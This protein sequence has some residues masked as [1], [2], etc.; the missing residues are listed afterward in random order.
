MLLGGL[1]ML[2]KGSDW[3]VVG[4]SDIAKA[5]KIPSLVIGLTIVAFGTSAPE[6][7]VS[8]SASLTG[9][10][11]VALGNVIG[12]NIFN[13]LMVVG[14]SSCIR[15][16]Y[17]EKEV[18]VRDYPFNIL[19]TLVLVFLGLDVFLGSGSFNEIS[20]V[21]GLVLLSFF[22]VFMY[23]TVV[24]AL[25]DREN[26]V[27]EIPERKMLMSI[28]LLVV[29]IVCVVAGGKF[30]VD[31]ACGIAR[32]FSVSENMIALT[33]IAIGTSLPELVT[34]VT[35]LKKGESD[36]AIGNVIGSNLFNIL[37]IIGISAFIRP[38]SVGAD[39]MTDALILTAVNL[40]VYSLMLKN[41]STSRLAGGFMILMYA[42]FAVFV[43]IRGIA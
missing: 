10:G 26:M 4:A 41:K 36:I 21:D 38:I 25:K 3:F 37:F 42:A 20:K 24:G 9:S 22:V 28:V 35:A 14:V 31:G 39:S 19:V 33:I 40:V 12:S 30:T 32:F 15:K 7:A 18:I 8:I 17:V 5:L 2:I 11:G 29:G 43:V 27:Q 16:L 1:V 34:S 23:Y 6:A 13:L